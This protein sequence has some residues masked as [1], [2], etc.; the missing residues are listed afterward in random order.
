MKYLAVA[1]FLLSEMVFADPCTY[2]ITGFKSADGLVKMELEPILGKGQKLTVNDDDGGVVL[3]LMASRCYEGTRGKPDTAPL[4]CGDEVASIVKKAA[5]KATEYT[6]SVIS[7]VMAPDY[8]EKLEEYN[9]SVPESQ[10]VSI[11]P[12]ERDAQLADAKKQNETVQKFPQL[13]KNKVT[14]GEF[15]SWLKEFQHFVDER[16]YSVEN[17]VGEQQPLENILVDLQIRLPSFESKIMRCGQTPPA[18]LI[19]QLKAVDWKPT[20]GGAGTAP[21]GTGGNR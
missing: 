10:R 17:N 9:K 8:F 13:L 6:D 14:N 11:T 16:G 19:E 5:E 2:K 20:V 3:A 18:N 1:L 4:E 21:S 12:A 7:Q 15:K